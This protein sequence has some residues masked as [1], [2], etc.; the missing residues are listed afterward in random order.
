MFWRN[1]AEANGV[2]GE[3]LRSRMFAEGQGK[4]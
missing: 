1:V 4:G 2:I 3:W